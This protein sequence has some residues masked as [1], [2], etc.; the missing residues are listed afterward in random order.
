MNHQSTGGDPANTHRVNAN[1][2]RVLLIDD[3]PSVRSE[4]KRWLVDGGFEVAEAPSAKDAL[5]LIARDRFDLVLSDASLPDIDGLELLRRMRAQL[6]DVPIV[7]MLD[8]PNNRVAIDAKELGAFES[9]IKPLD[10]PLLRETASIVV[11]QQRAARPQ[12]AVFRNRRGETLEPS[13]VTASEAK[14]EFGRVL[15]MA[16]QGGAVV[17]TKHD[18]PK[19]VLLSVEDFNALS[20]ANETRLDTLSHEFDALLAQMQTAKARRG[21]KRAFA[22]SGKELGKVAVAAARTRA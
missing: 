2:R 12:V 11:R 14:S 3:E 1:R 6:P 18:A 10:G 16:V 15:E 13:S 7:L 4:Y 19:A 9:L 8:R 5:R 20:R 22:A 17:I 21:M